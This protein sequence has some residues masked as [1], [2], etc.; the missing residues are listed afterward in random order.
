MI[1]SSILNELVKYSIIDNQFASFILETFCDFI[2][3]TNIIRYLSPLFIDYINYLI[4]I[5]FSFSSISQVFDPNWLMNLLPQQMNASSQ[6]PIQEFWKF[7]IL[8]M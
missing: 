1:D 6:Q 7:N 8:F 5:E 2:V 3:S 4:S